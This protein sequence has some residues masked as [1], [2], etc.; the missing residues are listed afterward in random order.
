MLDLRSR[1]LHER[2]DVTT[3]LDQ[4]FLILLAAL[5]WLAFS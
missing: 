3:Q 1:P 4:P 2:V 5:S